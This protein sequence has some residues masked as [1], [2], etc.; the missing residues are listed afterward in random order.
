VDSNGDGKLSE[1]D[2]KVVAVS[3]PGGLRLTRVLTAV[4]EVKGTSWTP[5]DRILVLYTVASTLKAALIDGSTFAVV[6][7][8]AVTPQQLSR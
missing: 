7:N 1:S 3:T 2:V 8:E 5:D 6:N 4:E